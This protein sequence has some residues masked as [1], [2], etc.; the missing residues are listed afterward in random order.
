VTDPLFVSARDRL[1]VALDIPSLEEARSFA[2]RMANEVG[3]IKVGLELFIE[4]GRDAVRLGEDVKRPVFLD[5]KL[6]DIPET[7]ERAV[8][9]VCAMGARLL[10]VHASGGPT[11]LER[12]VRR[13]EAENSGLQV[14]AV[15][16]LTSFD[17]GD[18]ASVGV[19]ST[20]AL[21]ARKLARMAWNA[22]VRAFVCS[23]HEAP[24]LREELG[25]SA[26]LIT[27]G[28][29]PVAGGDDQKRVSTARDAIRNG[30][31]A[32]VVGRPIRDAKDPV[33]A[34]RALVTEIASAKDHP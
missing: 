34:A 33:Q 31:T 30:S 15:T 13:A 27:P 12:A 28:V 5:L 4:A 32:V 11:M 29:R 7:V 25:E 26:I 16:V 8:G 21:H 18:L 22:G 14:V 19:P 6:H 20:T 23:P 2:H 17:D 9:R 1:I 10:T 24:S 3:V